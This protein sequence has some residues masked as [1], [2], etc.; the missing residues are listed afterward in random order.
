MNNCFRLG[1][2][3]T[4]IYH[5]QQHF[6]NHFHPNYTL[7]RASISDILDD[8]LL[9]HD[10]NNFKVSLYIHAPLNISNNL[11]DQIRMR[12]WKHQNPLHISGPQLRTS[13]ILHD[14]YLL[15]NSMLSDP[16]YSL[17]HTSTSNNLSDLQKQLRCKPP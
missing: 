10:S 1:T 13:N 8:H 5:N 17:A 16:L 4:L 3:S 9:L 12:L 7:S 6:Y 2:S 14:H 15:L 11:L